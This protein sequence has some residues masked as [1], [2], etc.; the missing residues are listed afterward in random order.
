MEKI[1]KEA[2]EQSTKAIESLE[3]RVE[4]LSKEYSEDIQEFWSDL[5]KGVKDINEKLKS[6][7]TTIEE[8]NDEAKLQANLGAMEA[9][10]R[11]EEIKGSLD[12]MT[13]KI[14]ADTQTAL[15]TAKLKAHLAKMEAEDFWE[16]RG[17][18][19]TNEFNTSK[20][21]VETLAVEAIKE[22]G[23]FFEK[24]TQNITEKKS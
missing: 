6:S 22:I 14:G 24:L 21:K 20:E 7:A 8:S 17:K 18:E 16:E 9:R 5:K 12:A 15:D 2:I 23:S 11:V 3:E 10:D 19:I 1:F 13:Q 4:K